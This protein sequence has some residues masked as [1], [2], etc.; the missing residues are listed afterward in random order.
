MYIANSMS[1]DC[2]LIGF[3]D[4]DWSRDIDNQHSGGVISWLSREQ[5][6]L[7]SLVNYIFL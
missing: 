4:A 3:S 7:V 1:V 6:P 5:P 2:K